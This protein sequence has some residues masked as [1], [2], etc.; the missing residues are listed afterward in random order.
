MSGWVGEFGCVS[1]GWLGFGGLGGWVCWV[2]WVGLFCGQ[3]V[4]R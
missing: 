1:F 3:Q 2:G 4:G